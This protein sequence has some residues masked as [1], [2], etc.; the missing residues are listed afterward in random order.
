MNRYTVLAH[1]ITIGR[2]TYFNGNLINGEQHDE[3][4]L[5][6]LVAINAIKEVGSEKV[7]N[8]PIPK[9]ELDAE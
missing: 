3:S 1:N 9:E 6:H 4:Q 2:K 5:A 8:S 7:G